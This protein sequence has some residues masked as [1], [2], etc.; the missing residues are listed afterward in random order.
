[1][2]LPTPAPQQCKERALGP[3]K[4]QLRPVLS[5]IPRVRL[6]RCLPQI[7][8]FRKKTIEGCRGYA[9]N[10]ALALIV[11]DIAADYS[12]DTVTRWPTF[13][14]R[15]YGDGETMWVSRLIGTASSVQDFAR[16][17][18]GESVHAPVRSVSMCKS[19]PE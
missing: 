4:T 9:K 8:H 5:D 2:R 10:G 15:R 1:M 6:V 19:D 3:S 7:P 13:P 16:T 17:C 12:G 14:V 18:R 11:L